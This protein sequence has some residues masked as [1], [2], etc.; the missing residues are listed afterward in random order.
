ML[1]QQHIVRASLLCFSLG[2][3]I[4]PAHA[5]HTFECSIVARIQMTSVIDKVGILRSIKAKEHQWASQHNRDLC[6]GDVVIVPKSIPHLEINYHSEEPLKKILVAGERHKVI[7]LVEPC[8]KWC[9][10]HKIKSLYEKLT[11]LEPS[12]QPS[13]EE[14]WQESKA[15][16]FHPIFTPL[17]NNENSDHPFYLFSRNEVVPLFWYGGQPPYQLEVKNAIGEMVVQEITETANFSL[18][19]PNTEP[20]SEYFLTIKTAKDKSCYPGNSKICDKKL[21]VTMPPLPMDPHK[22]GFTLTTLLADCEKNWRLE[23]WRRFSLM[24]KSEKNKRFMG[25]LDANDFDLTK[26]ELCHH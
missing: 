2:A 6:A 18:T 11:I 8:G 7:K 3:S 24:P 15:G 13:K 10:N 25:H 22:E 4:S 9:K 16:K 21:I 19:L 20:S 26:E 17:A 14:N 23:L 12:N 1:N 5:F